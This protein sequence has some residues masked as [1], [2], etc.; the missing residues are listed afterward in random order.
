MNWHSKSRKVNRVQSRPQA[1]Q[2]HAG[3]EE[4]EHFPGGSYQ[5]WLATMVN[6]G[7]QS[8]IN[9]QQHQLDMNNT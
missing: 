6:E 7:L 3:R 2:L 1:E 4:S 9:R 5:L 8:D